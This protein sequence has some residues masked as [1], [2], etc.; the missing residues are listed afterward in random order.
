[1][2]SNR[3]FVRLDVHAWSVT[4]HGLDGS[5]GQV[6]QQKLT[7]D[8][9]D[10]LA[11]VSGLPGPVK[12]GY[13]AGPTGYGLFRFLNDHGVDGRNSCVVGAPSKLHRP[14]GDRLKT[15]A[16]DAELLARC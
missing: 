13:E 6:S 2:E 5:T 4:G 10:I 1:M 14:H 9:A 12:V 3:S 11:W 15:D 8:P 16:R 7:P